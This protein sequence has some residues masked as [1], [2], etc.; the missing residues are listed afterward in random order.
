MQSEKKDEEIQHIGDTADVDIS[1]KPSPFDNSHIQV[2]SL[3]K[4]TP[5][6]A[7]WRFRRIGLFCFLAAFSSSMDGF[8]GKRSLYYLIEGMS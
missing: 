1:E 2:S 8:Q 3:D 7:A 6:Q 4:L 5:F